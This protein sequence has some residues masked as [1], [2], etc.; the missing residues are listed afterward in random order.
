MPNYRFIMK[1]IIIFAVLMAAVKLMGCSSGFLSVH[2]IDVQQGNALNP[3]SVE[4][5]TLGMNTEQV[6]YLLGYPVVTDL[7]HPDRWSYIY[8]FKPGNGHVE[9][10]RLTVYFNNDRV[11]RIEKPDSTKFASRS[12]SGV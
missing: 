8:Y 11:V 7:F 10:R 9:N 4:L 3:E 5:I 12:G 2:K 6:R 1:K